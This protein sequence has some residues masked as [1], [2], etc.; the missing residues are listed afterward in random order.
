MKKS[1]QKHRSV[2]GKEFLN[3]FSNKKIQSFFEGTVGAGGHAKALLEAHPELARYLACDRDS[4]ALELSRE[5]L[6]PWKD[7]V[8]FVHANF[9]DLDRVLKAKKIDQVDGFFLILG[10]LQCN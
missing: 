6:E 3:F 10:F 1:D 4:Q 7:K 5:A 2:M 9:S 8:E